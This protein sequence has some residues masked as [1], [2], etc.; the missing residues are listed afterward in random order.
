MS[1]TTLVPAQPGFFTYYVDATPGDEFYVEASPVVAWAVSTERDPNDPSVLP[2]TVLGDADI[3]HLLLTPDGRTFDY[4]SETW[5]DSLGEA[6]DARVA[7]S[8]K[9]LA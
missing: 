6:V 5:H 8:L 9:G 3:H 7:K 2:V 4:A 1:S